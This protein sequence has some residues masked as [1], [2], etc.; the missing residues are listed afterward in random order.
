[1]PSPA[2]E[3]QLCSGPFL[4]VTSCCFLPFS[5]S[6][7]GWPRFLHPC[8]SICL[9]L[10]V[11]SFRQ[12]T[13]AHFSKG[14][15]PQSRG[16]LGNF[17]HL[18]QGKAAWYDLMRS[19]SQNNA[20]LL[21]SLPRAQHQ[22]PCEDCGLSWG[23]GDGLDG[24]AAGEVGQVFAIPASRRERPPLHWQVPTEGAWVRLAVRAAGGLGP[25]Q[26]SRE[27]PSG[28]TGSCSSSHFLFFI[29]VSLL[30]LNIFLPVTSCSL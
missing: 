11:G 18:N 30:S 10:P 4:Q 2:R 6:P 16:Q 21:V 9:A 1:M 23:W 22:P 5:K 7:E 26:R 8:A 17:P 24:L 28:K 29:P 12:L 19:V 14:R 20:L 15:F 25:S 3:G 13:K 27:L